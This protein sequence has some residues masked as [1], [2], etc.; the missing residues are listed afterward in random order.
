MP[1][2]STKDSSK[3]KQRIPSRVL[4]DTNYSIAEEMHPAG[5]RDKTN[6]SPSSSE[7]FAFTCSVCGE[8]H[9]ARV[10]A[11]TRAHDEGDERRA[12]KGC[13]ARGNSKVKAR[14]ELI[15]TELYEELVPDSRQTP[16]SQVVTGMLEHRHWDCA[17]GLADGKK[18]FRFA[19][20]VAA[21]TRYGKALPSKDDPQ[22]C[23]KCSYDG[24]RVD[25]DNKKIYRPY[26]KMLVQDKSN[27]GYTAITDS[28]PIWHKAFFKCKKGHRR[29]CSLEQ[30]VRRSGCLTCFT[31]LHKGKNLADDKFK[32]WHDEYVCVPKYPA[33]TMQDVSSSS[34]IYAVLWRCRVDAR[35]EW[36][37]YPFRRTRDE[38]GCPYC[39]GHRL[40][41]GESLT[42]KFPLIA[43]EFDGGENCSKR[44]GQPL[45]PLHIHP[46]DLRKYW[47]LCSCSHLYECSVQARTALGKGCPE[48]FVRAKSLASERPDLASE[49]HTEGNAK[50]FPNLT[51]NNVTLGSNKKV[52]WQCSSAP[53]HEWQ[54][55][56]KNRVN[57]SSG[58]PHCYAERRKKNKKVVADYEKAK[59]RFDEIL[60]N[61]PASRAA[62]ITKQVYFWTCA[63]GTSFE[64][65]WA[66][67]L[68]R[69]FSCDDC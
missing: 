34:R 10:A 36:R 41:V 56:V 7:L 26:L 21:R 37:A 11:K 14:P 24:P 69:G 53:E 30:M 25:A 13:G 23:P 51:A 27:I 62:A 45:N 46:H 28:F 5:G 57:K 15:S 52:W 35:H 9:E 44:T 1:R 20:S 31:E 64:K 48:C 2:L 60:N 19:A 18:K 12:C 22:H 16:K 4:V 3:N 47:F 50:L 32:E 38:Q 66:D 68:R 39:A 6:T 49:W 43:A 8:T 42:E 40:V 55:E 54:A 33:L 63:C 65:R 58:C 17:C 61:M 59:E 29:Y 67:V